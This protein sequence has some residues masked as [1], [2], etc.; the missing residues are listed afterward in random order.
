MNEKRICST[1]LITTLI[2]G[3]TAAL[4]VNVFAP[5]PVVVLPDDLLL[6]AGEVIV[7]YGPGT[8]GTRTLIGPGVA[9][10]L[11][12]LQIGQGTLIGDDFPVDPRAGGALATFEAFGPTPSDFCEYTSYE[13]IFSNPS[14]IPVYVALYINTGWTIIPPSYAT[15]VR[16]TYFQSDWVQI[17]PGQTRTVIMDFSSTQVY[18]V[19]DDLDP[20]FNVL[21][22]GDTGVAVFRCDEVSSI[23]FQVR[24]DMTGL[25]KLDLTVRQGIPEAAV[26][27]IST[28]VNKL[29]ILAPYIAIALAIAAVVGIVAFKRSKD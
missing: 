16:D 19:E 2:F 11:T 3:I 7:E 9:F 22:N 4:T 12:G 27:G 23:G 10:T 8:I 13:M 25:N 6:D 28:P 21:N 15:G 29:A 14:T 17:D 26:G 20:T 1:L 24:A 5:P 18:E